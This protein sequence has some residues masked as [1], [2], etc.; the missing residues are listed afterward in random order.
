MLKQT[1]KLTS[2]INSIPEIEKF[3]RG[4]KDLKTDERNR[5]MIISSEIFENL[6]QHSDCPGSEVSF[7]VIKNSSL[8]VIFRFTS[9]NFNIQVVNKNSQKVYFDHNSRR[10]R[11]MGF[12]MCIN[13]SLSMRLRITKHYNAISFRVS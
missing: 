10:Y 4:L 7:R 13:L 11:G 3:I 6:I 5:L 12:I 9:N 8:S 1:L 2:C